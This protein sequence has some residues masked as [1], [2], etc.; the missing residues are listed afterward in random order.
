MNLRTESKIILVILALGVFV[1]EIVSHG[2]LMEPPARNCMWRFGYPTPVNYDDNQLWCGGAAVMNLQNH[3]KCGVCGDNYADPVPRSHEAGGEYAS[4]IIVRRYAPG[5]TFDMEIELTANHQGTFEFKLCPVKD[6]SYEVTQECL[7]SHHL[8]LIDATG[9]VAEKYVI[10]SQEKRK[11]FY[12]QAKLPPYTS[13]SHCVLQWTYIAANTWGTCANGTEAVGCGAQERFINCADIAV[14]QNTG[15][16]PPNFLTN[17]IIPTPNIRV[18]GKKL[19]FVLRAQVC[20][21]RGHYIGDKEMD[22]WCHQN[23]LRFPP[24]CPSDKCKCL[25]GCNA[26]GSFKEQEGSDVYCMD[27]CLVYP[28]KNCTSERCSCY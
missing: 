7:D 2:R 10:M 8:K 25:S 21:A 3:G 4:G 17:S 27:Q 26:V 24:N 19:P 18:G 11:T 23:C 1:K 12:L 13:C 9:L 14:I 15:G 5:Q 28:P 6:P 22:S 20:V 16:R